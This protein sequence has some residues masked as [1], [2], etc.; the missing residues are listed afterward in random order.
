[1]DMTPVYR[2]VYIGIYVL[3]DLG[4]RAESCGFIGNSD[5][6]KTGRITGLG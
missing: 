6:T 2:L 3:F 4:K 5:E 1:M